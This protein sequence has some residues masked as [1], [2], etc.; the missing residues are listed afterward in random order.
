MQLFN[1]YLI[2][3]ILFYVLILI[4]VITQHILIFQCFR[5]LIII[6]LVVLHKLAYTV[7]IEM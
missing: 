5:Y 3:G 2:A 1:E 4:H 7:C 6:F